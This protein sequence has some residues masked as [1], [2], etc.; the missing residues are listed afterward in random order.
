MCR[1]VEPQLGVQVLASGHR[2]EWNNC[3]WRRDEDSGDENGGWGWGHRAVIEDEDG[4]L[5]TG[6][7][8]VACS[9]RDIIC[10]W[11]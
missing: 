11:Q 2:L 9:N 8:M 6:T 4:R 3:D 5:W 1:V 7:W 10:E